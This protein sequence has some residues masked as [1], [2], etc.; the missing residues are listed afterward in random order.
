MGDNVKPIGLQFLDLFLKRMIA[1]NNEKW[2]QDLG[3][4]AE[5]L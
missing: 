4:G 3:Q 2:N 1:Y 5:K